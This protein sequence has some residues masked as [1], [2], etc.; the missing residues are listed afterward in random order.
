MPPQFSNVLERYKHCYSELK[1]TQFPSAEQIIDTF[2]ARDAVQAHLGESERSAAELIELERLD[3]GLKRRMQELG[4]RLPTKHRVALTSQLEA[5]RETVHPG[6]A[7]WWWSLRL[8]VRW[9]DRLDLFWDTLAL[10][11]LAITFSLLT[12]ITSRFLGGNPGTFGAF[13]IIVQAILALA[14]GGA[15]T[16]TGQTFVNNTL[17]RWKVPRRNWQAVKFLG[18]TLLLLLF[19]GFRLSLPWIAVQYNNAGV[20]RFIAGEFD[21]AE[22]NLQRS[23]ALDPNYASAN[24]NLGVLY[25]QLGKTEDAQVQYRYAVAAGIDAAYSNLG[26]LYI[27]AGKNSEAATLLLEGLAK[28]QD[29]Q[30]RYSLLRNLGWVRLNQKRFQQARE[31]LE[32][33]IAIREFS[34]EPKVHCL[35]AQTLDGLGDRVK[36]LSEWQQCSSL[37]PQGQKTP[38]LDTWL[39]M[40][41][42][43]LK[44]GKKKP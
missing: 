35:M 17:R 32:E 13:A 3:D 8:P 36:A 19:I 7:D 25:E 16:R 24:Y 11:W 37:P 30:V 2:V 28:S 12:D 15:L 23:L 31:R 21:E 22:S 14:G 20:N 9:W 27:Q 5:V 42:E 38:E 6:E 43:R 29:N 40:A 33:A 18:A 41:E 34:S 26:R 4:C 10:I 39:G 44:E 1:K